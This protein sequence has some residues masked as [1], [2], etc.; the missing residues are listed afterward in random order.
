[1]KLSTTELYDLIKRILTANGCSAEVAEIVTQTVY[2]A[3]VSGTLSHGVFRLP[4]Y[5]SSLRAGWVDGTATPIVH[6]RAPGVVVVD[7]NNGFSQVAQ[8]AGRPLVMEKARANGVAALTIRNAHH[9]AALWPDLEPFGEQGLAAIGF[10]NT[11]SLVAP[12]GGSRKLLGTNPMAF[13]WPRHNRPPLLWDQA[14]SI[15]AHGEVLMAA[16]EGR[17]LPP[18]TGF[19]ADGNP[20]TDPARVAEGALNPFGRHKGTAIALMVELLTAGLGGANFGFQDKG[21]DVP[22]ARTFNGGMTIL[23]IDPG[24]FD[25]HLIERAE[26]FFAVYAQLEG[27][28]LPGE[29]RHGS[30]ARA[31]A[32]GVT[33]ADAQYSALLELLPANEA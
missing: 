11:M 24:R 18:D 9:F 4:G 10:V 8:R 14:S 12:W 21:K 22:G 5:V 1:M 33:I 15:M 29:R 20:S 16:R 2:T 3:E 31:D 17:Q 30:R 13:A 32:E 7:G 26:D 28:R 19:D 25:D 27:A 23:V 6:D